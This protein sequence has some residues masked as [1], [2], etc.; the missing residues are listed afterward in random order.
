MLRW[1]RERRAAGAARSASVPAEAKASRTGAILA[2]H[3][4]GR[5]VWTSRS[6]AALARA[7]YMRNPVAYRCV[8]M[9]A[10]AAA[11]LPWLVYESGREAGEHPLLALLDRP[12]PR[13]AGGA[14]MEAAYGHLLLSGNAYLEAVA[15]DGAVRE[16]HVLRPD[17][18]AVVPDADGW[19]A[20]YEYAAN[21][22]SVRFE[23]E[24]GGP[25]PPILHLAQ[26]HPLDDHYGFAPIDAAQASLDLHNQAGAW[27]KALLDNAARPSG[28][29]VYQAKDGGNLSE[30][31]FE[32]LKAELEANFQ[33]AANAGRPLLLEGG[34]AWQAM[35]H[36]PREMDY[37]EAKNNAAREIALA[38]GVPPMLLGI[39]GDNTYANY[40]EANLAFWRQTVLPLAGRTAQALGRW[41]A[42]AFGGDLRLWYDV[43]EVEALSAER[44][45]VWRRVKGADFLSEDEKRA[46]VGYGPREG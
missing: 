10:E 32:R 21:G 38:F 39:P 14:L 1:L 36:S 13:L 15:I 16:L 33:G 25:V 35:S 22:R 29:L 5:P 3:G 44:E 27:N 8:R 28:A 23:Q 34:L 9:V 4:A 12:N 43:D 31:Q 24:G 7:G 46:A 6:Y 45:A 30:T 20:A 40:R 26:F 37:L 42:P 11:A 17:R 18:M 2:L 41:L 19:P